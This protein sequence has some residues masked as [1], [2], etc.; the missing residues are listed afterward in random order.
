MNTSLELLKTD[1]IDIY[2]FHCASQV[3]KPDD[4]TGM[5]E[6]MLEAKRQG[7]IKHIGITAH[8]LQVAFD[9]VESGLYETLQFPLSY[10]ST[11]QEIE[12][13]KKCQRKEHGFYCNERTR[14]RFD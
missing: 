1:Y 4:G 6:C 10:L 11:E 13:V 14:W 5:Y 9:A 8:L 2:Q 3:Y 12:L 7:K